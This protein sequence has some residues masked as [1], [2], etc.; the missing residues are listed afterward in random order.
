M[1]KIVL[2]IP[3]YNEEES[4]PHLY[5]ALCETADMMK[6]FELEFMFINDGSSD[7]TLDMLKELSVS[8][9]RVKYLSF[10]RNFGKEAAMYAGFCNSN[11]DYTA[12][13][14][15]DMQDPPSLLP[16]M[17]ELLESG[18]YDSVATRRTTRK[19]EPALRSAFARLFYKIIRKISDSDIVDGARDFRL[20]RREMVEA[21][22]KMSE[23]NR[24]SKGIFGWIGF[25]TYWM[26]YENVERVSGKT[27]WS[28]WGLLKYA[29]DGIINFS[30][31]PLAMAS[32]LGIS[33]TM[34]SFLA[35]II[36]VVRKL[37]FGDPIQ[38]WAST[39]CIIIFMGGIQLFCTG[40]LG[41][42]MAKTYIETK[43]R[44]HYIISETNK[45]DCKKI[46]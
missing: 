33:F 16:K 38:G 39:I 30:Q 14:D 44:P 24:F 35:I 21:I 25:R 17:V 1:K 46:M 8:D 36:I 31:A 20:M 37:I 2:V 34:L 5:K 22:V 9:K 13:M 29:V 6:S 18:E 42:Y 32:W 4:L 10:S 15:A 45:E 7:K 19:G 26:P 28:F 43:N 3:A 12:V 41:Q 27:K 23:N 40:V 11:G